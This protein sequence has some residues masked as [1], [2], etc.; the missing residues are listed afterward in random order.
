MRRRRVQTLQAA[1]VEVLESRQLL[2]AAVVAEVRSID[3]T[4]NNL[5]HPDWGS[6]GEAL[7]RLSP[8]EYE[9]GLS[10]LAGQDRPGPRA[11]SNALAAQDPDETIVDSRQLSGFAYLWGQFLDHDLDLT[12]TGGDTLQIAIPAGDPQ[13]D[14]DG[15]GTKVINTRRSLFDPTTGTTTPREHI[16]SITAWIDGSMVYGSNAATATS[17]RELS[18]GRLK[19]S[20]GNLLPKN[21]QGSFLAGDTRANENIELTSLHVLFLR[22]HNYWAAKFAQQDPS[23]TDE[24]LY[25]KARERVIGEIQSITYNEYLPALLGSKL[26]RYTGYDSSVNPGISTEFSTAGFRLGHSMLANNVGYVANSGGEAADAI[27]LAQA[28]GNPSLVNND[29]VSHL[30]KF[31][32]SDPSSEIDNK[33]VDGVRNLL[34]FAQG[35]TNRLDLASLNILR[36]RDHG[37]ADYNTVREAYGLPRVTRF[38]QITADVDVRNQLRDLYG[39]VDNIDLWVG[40]LAERHTHGSVGETVHAIVVDQFERLRDGDRFWYQNVFRGATLRQIEG[41]TLATIISRNT[42]ITNLQENVFYFRASISGTVTLANGRTASGMTVE[43]VNR[44]SGEVVAS[45]TTNSRGRYNFSIDDGLRTGRFLVRLYGQSSGGYASITKGDEF[46]T[47]DLRLTRQ[48]PVFA[49]TQPRTS[50]LP[51]KTSTPVV[52][53]KQVSLRLPQTVAQD[54]KQALT[55]PLSLESMTKGLTEVPTTVLDEVFADG[56]SLDS[57]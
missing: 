29:S 57:L 6:A 3:G 52:T 36:G 19:T 47:V 46:R 4:G 35:S 53:G 2:S 45:E 22:E 27:T 10:T 34:V 33:I 50:L 39:S 49:S 23:L 20:E 40:M 55:S 30:L 16:N 24:Q 9:D 56:A 44:D 37:L 5:D 28:F 42:N 8:A 54:E 25:Q 38:S 1:Q 48:V 7:L 12:P 17:L 32:A 26:P 11:I 51:D 18:G 43:L 13:F 31:L 14:P 15:T 21:A 41:T